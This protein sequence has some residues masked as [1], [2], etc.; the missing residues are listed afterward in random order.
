[1]LQAIEVGLIAIELALQLS[2]PVQV[3]LMVSGFCPQQGGGPVLVFGQ[4]GL[5]L[6]LRTRPFRRKNGTGFLTLQARLWVLF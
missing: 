3:F 1:M 5:A 4:Q 6:G 2:D